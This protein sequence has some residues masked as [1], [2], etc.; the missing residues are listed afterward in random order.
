[1]STTTP[2]ASTPPAAPA[3][4]AATPAPTPAPPTDPPKETDWKAEARK[5]EER[6]KENKKALDDAK[7]KL[8]E[9]DRLRAASQTEL[10]KAQEL[11]AQ[12]AKERDDAATT[13]AQERSER[14]R[15]KVALDKSLPATL[16]ARLQGTTEEEM[17][18][19]ADALLALLPKG[20]TIP[21]PNPAQGSSA[22][23]PPVTPGQLS[24]ADVKRMYAEKRYGEIE[25][26]RSEGRLATILGATPP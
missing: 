14:L 4:P 19:D 25:Q 1:M 20:S 18:A 2:E 13:L 22:G 15:L 16:A 26:A 8:D 12:T 9:W 10:E 23:G 11:A 3:A 24:E 21:K 5:W 6:A 17:A 7:P